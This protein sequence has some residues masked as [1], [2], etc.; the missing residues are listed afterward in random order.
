M[1]NDYDKPINLGNPSECTIAEL[2]E[3]VLDL[4]NSSSKIINKGR[5]IDDPNQRQPDISLAREILDWNPKTD[6]RSG[7]Y[8]TIEYF[9]ELA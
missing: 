4:T 5:P 1:D 6:L 8:L 2:A 7:L 9:K 3:N